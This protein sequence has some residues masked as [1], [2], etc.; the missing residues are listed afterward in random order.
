MKWPPSFACDCMGFH[1]NMWHV[2]LG[3]AEA[4]SD[5]LIVL[6]DDRL[7]VRDD[8]I[9]VLIGGEVVRASVLRVGHY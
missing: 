4:R 3:T 6:H 5:H 1:Q 9:N 2:E 7:G 8:D